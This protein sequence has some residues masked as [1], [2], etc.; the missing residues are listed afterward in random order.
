M[1]EGKAEETEE[2]EEEKRD[3]IKPTQHDKDITAKPESHITNLDGLVAQE[4]SCTDR[5]QK[6]Y[7]SLIQT[8]SGFNVSNKTM[9]SQLREAQ[10]KIDPLQAERSTLALLTLL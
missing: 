2:A 9:S 5:L 8:A 4:K 7:D 6:R 10:A 1:E 3:I